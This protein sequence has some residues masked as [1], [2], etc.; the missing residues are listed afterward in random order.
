MRRGLYLRASA[1]TGGMR[2]QEATS[3]AAPTRMLTA[4]K[5]S[6]T[7]VNYTRYTVVRGG[8]TRRGQPDDG[9]HDQRALHVDRHCIERSGLHS[10]STVQVRRLFSE[11]VS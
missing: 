6:G 2:A 8:L 7:R 5:L 4:R 3:P 11:F 1:K 10:V 9:E